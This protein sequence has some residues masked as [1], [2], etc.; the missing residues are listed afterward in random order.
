MAGHSDPEDGVASSAAGGVLTAAG[1]SG[2]IAWLTIADPTSSNEPLWPVFGFTEVA[3]IGLYGMLA[4]LLR[5]WPCD[6]SVKWLRSDV[7]P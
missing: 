7:H 2:A 6:V 1:V 3:V 4:P 5:W